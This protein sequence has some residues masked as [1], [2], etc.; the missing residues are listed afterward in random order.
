MRVCT[1]CGDPKSLDLFVKNK[2]S[3]DGRG[4]WCLL[5]FSEYMKARR[6]SNPESDRQHRKVYRVA[7]IELVRMQGREHSRVRQE[8]INTFKDKPCADCG[9]NFPTCCMDFDHVRG[10]KLKGIGRMMTFSEV[11]VL[12]EVA[13]CKVVCACCHRVRTHPSR[14][15]CGNPGRRRFYSKIDAL[16]AKPCTDC[17][18]IFP[19]VAMD[20]DH[21]RGEKVST[22]AQMRSIAWEQVLVEL[23]K[24]ELVCACCH[25]TRTQTRKFHSRAA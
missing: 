5:C 22:I 23:V 8:W 13:K 25:R 7:H 9:R 4:S 6:R 2:H 10:E 21:V 3:H 24:C 18:L 1:K 17:G 14:E 11:R 15:T 20:F 19:P 16:K 12:E